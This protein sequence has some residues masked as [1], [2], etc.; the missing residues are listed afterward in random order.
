MTSFLDIFLITGAAV[1]TAVSAFKLGRA[2][3]KPSKPK[4]LADLIDVIFTWD[5]SPKQIKQNFIN[6]LSTDSIRIVGIPRNYLNHSSIFF[7]KKNKQLYVSIYDQVDRYLSDQDLIDMV[8][9][10]P[11]ESTTP[12]RG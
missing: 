9:P 8:R 12:Y 2:V 7:N 3:E 10:P 4:P 1:G 5:Y 6:N 11:E